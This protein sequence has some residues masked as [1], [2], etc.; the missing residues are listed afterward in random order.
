MFRTGRGP[1]PDVSGAF[2]TLGQLPDP[3][4]LLLVDDDEDQ[5]FAVRTA[6]RDFTAPRFVLTVADSHDTGLQALER[7]EFDVCLVDFD[8]GQLNG[9]NLIRSARTVGSTVPFVLFTGHTE[10][11]LDLAAMAVGA[12]DFLPKHRLDRAVLERTLRYAIVQDRTQR[13]LARAHQRMSGLD[14]VGRALVANG[15][16]DSTLDRACEILWERF[17]FEFVSIY[18]RDGDDLILGGSRGYPNPI[19]H[20]ALNWGVIRHVLEESEPRLSP[21]ISHDPAHRIDGLRTEYLVPLHAIDRSVG[22]LVIGSADDD[23]IGGD[24]KTVVTAIATRI[25]T[26]LRL[27]AEIRS[28]DERVGAMLRLAALGRRLEVALAGDDAWDLVAEAIADAL[29]G[30]HASVAHASAAQLARG[31]AAS[32]LEPLVEPFRG[33]QRLT[34]GLTVH[35][36]PVVIVERPGAGFSESDLDLVRAAQ[37]VMA[38]AVRLAADQTDRGVPPAG[39]PAHGALDLAVEHAEAIVGAQP[40]G[41]S[42]GVLLVGTGDG[43]PADGLEALGSAIA[44]RVGPNGAVVA[45]DDSGLGIVV[46]QA[47][48]SGVDAL[49]RL[50]SDL[51]GDSSAWRVGWA[52]RPAG[53][54]GEASDVAVAARAALALARRLPGGGPVRA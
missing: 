20:M 46:S 28:R 15:P 29:P 24:D 3:V 34:V 12:I 44:R 9:L 7:Q 53:D 1:V 18:R 38:M 32:P 26:S 19:E 31:A 45:F 11:T 39:V 40:G 43:R 10:R 49:A 21:V 41:G 5:H 54:V 4:R 13:Q 23:Q 35:D 36:G 2:D 42:I 51:A 17:G 16:T 27:H 25:G 37:P 14:D 30:T 8:L 52:F 50:I 47:S 48:E 33:G 22:L 6:L